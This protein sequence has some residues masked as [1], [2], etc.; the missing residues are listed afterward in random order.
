M[1]EG[2]LKCSGI[3]VGEFSVNLL[4]ATVRMR[5][6]A[7]FIDPKTGATHGWTEG[8]VWA[9]AT[10]AK[11]RELVALMEEDLAR[12]HFVGGVEAVNASA[13]SLGG[14]AGGL[15]EHIGDDGEQV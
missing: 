8:G 6:K 15:G 3:A 7:A 2:S 11:M 4:D 1:I 14:L 9:P 10:V 13:A 12:Q 5:A